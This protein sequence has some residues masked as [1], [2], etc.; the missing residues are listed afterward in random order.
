[1]SRG[2]LVTGASRGIGRAIATAFATAGD[3]VAVHCSSRPDDAARTVR[4]LPGTGHV[5]LRADIAD[6]GQ[7][8]RLVA[9]AVT[10]LGAL[11][12]LVNNAAVMTPH[13]P[14][15]TSYADWQDAWRSTVEVNLLGAANL[16]H[17]VA[18][19]LIGRGAEGRIV[20]VGSRGAFR[21]EPDHP[22]YAASKA[23]LHALGQ[24]LAVALGPHGIGVASVAPGF[25]DTERV[26][27]RLA[28]RQGEDIRAQSPFR[29]VAAPEE[30]ASAVVYLASPE[31]TWSS[32]AVLD[33]NGASYLRT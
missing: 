26:T 27:D 1:M 23:A 32:G 25:V 14:A 13:P 5:L 7:V 4:E 12:V 30:V 10:G 19:H 21:G 11:D 22:A 17:Q 33:V 6:P 31:A 9:D 15:T 16:S 8:Q 29:R 18:A 20:N 28:G 3:R 2:V 24:S